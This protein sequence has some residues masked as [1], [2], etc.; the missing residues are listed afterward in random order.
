V[1]DPADERLARVRR[2]AG[3]ASSAEFARAASYANEVWIGRDVVV[4]V[5]ARGDGSLRR[6]AAIAARV[7]AAVRYPAIVARGAE[8][9][10]DWMVTRRV[11]GIPLGAAWPSLDGARRERAIHELAG[12]L[13]A[14]HAAPAEGLP[15]DRDLAP[16][17]VLP[18]DRLLELA[19]EVAALGVEEVLVREVERFIGE[20]WDAF[21]DAELVLVHGDPHL[22]NV[23]WDGEHVSAVLDLEWSRRSYVEVDLEI[24]LSICSEPALFATIEEDALAPEQFADVPRWLADAAPAWFRHPRLAD[25][26]DVLRLSRTLGCFEEA[27]RSA[28]RIAHLR[29]IIAGEGPFRRWR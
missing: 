23:L 20:R 22:E 24:L 28:L 17:H 12:A 14:L 2:A 4:R 10:C 5:N 13:L 9:D 1:A 8:A 27:P 3:I 7:P 15:G 16:P 19:A 6:E 11:A 29:E 26:L 21:D 25:R 18:L